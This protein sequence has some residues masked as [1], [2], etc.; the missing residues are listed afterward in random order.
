M[1]GQVDNP[2]PVSFDDDE[3]T[4]QDDPTRDWKSGVDHKGQPLANPRQ[5]VCVIRRSAV[6]G[7]SEEGQTGVEKSL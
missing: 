6:F 1:D 5:T 3:G 2:A 7:P 4:P